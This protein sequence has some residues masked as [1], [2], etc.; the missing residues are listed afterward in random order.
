[1]P[2]LPTVLSQRGLK[3]EVEAARLFRAVA[4]AR[5]TGE[6][7]RLLEP[8]D[9]ERLA[10]FLDER[11]VLLEGCDACPSA[12][13]RAVVSVPKERCEVCA[14]S[15]IQR[16]ARTF[17]DACLVN[18]ATRVVIVGGSPKYH[19]QLRELVQHH[20]IKLTL[21]SGV[22]RRTAKQAKADQEHNDLVLLWGGTLLDHS[23]SELYG[24]GPA[25]VLTVPHRGIS[26]MLLRAAEMLSGGA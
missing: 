13:G 19:R 23:V 2:D 5:R 17:L 8:V 14:G 11:V 18:G 12:G 6:L 24:A 16:A 26:L 9:A 1:V 21:V 3:W 15:D 22:G 4:E 7:V 10:G 20:R 25:R